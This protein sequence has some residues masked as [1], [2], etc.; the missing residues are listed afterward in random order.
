MVLILVLSAVG[1]LLVIAELI[2]PGGILGILGALALIG[3]VVATFLEFGIGA[4]ILACFLLILLGFATLGWWMKYFHKLPVTRKLILENESGASK[5]ED[6]SSNL[7]GER[8]TA[9]TDIMP[10]GN[11][12]VDGAKRDAIAESGPIRKDSPLEVVAMRGS[13]VV[14]RAID[15]VSEP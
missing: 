4:G 1:I 12:L 2:L 13:A 11:A 8:G 9:L 6:G 7:I 3:A 10:S 5:A 15:D 14:V